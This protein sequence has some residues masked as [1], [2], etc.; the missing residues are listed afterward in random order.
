MPT[1]LSYL[2]FIYF[3]VDI[4]NYEVKKDDK[5]INGNKSIDNVNERLENF[6]DSII[7]RIL[8]IGALIAYIMQ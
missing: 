8:I 6:S 5:D 1:L 3:A 2:A 4:G 7:G